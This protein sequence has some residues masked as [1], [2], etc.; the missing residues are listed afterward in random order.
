M[1]DMLSG[2]QSYKSPIELFLGRIRMELDSQ[3]E[4][5]VYRA[6]QDINVK[7]D[8]EEL[9]KALAYDRQQYQKG[10][11]D[12]FGAAQKNNVLCRDCRHYWAYPE[13]DDFDGLCQIRHCQ[14][15]AEEFCSY[16]ERKDNEH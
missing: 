16:G 10:Y 9:I 2:F 15:D 11:K 13:P 12:G 7:V 14:T 3:V 8:K 1:F 5:A 4:G 6:V